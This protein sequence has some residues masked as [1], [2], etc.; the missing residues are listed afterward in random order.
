[1]KKLIRPAIIITLPAILAACAGMTGSTAAPDVPAAVAVPS[2]NKPAMTLVGAGLLTYECR[3][4]A[5]ADTFEW[6]FAGPDAKLT[7]KG[8]AVVGKYYG[9][10]TWEH[11]DGSK[12]TG[13]QL[14][15]SPSSAG[16]IPMQLVQ[17][18]PATGSG[19]FSGVT[20]IHRLNTK[21]GVAPTD[22]CGAA[23]SG[24]KKTVNYSADY[25][26]YKK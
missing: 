20:Y 2:G 18:N 13:K 19:A 17:A 12:V 10:P 8:G 1:M 7:D 4:K 16:N 15:V 9:G 26:F 21:G 24:A 14:A 22:P 3:A 6:A 23:T 11:S 25:V 5:G